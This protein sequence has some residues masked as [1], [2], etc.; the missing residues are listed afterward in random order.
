MSSKVYKD[1]PCAGM[2]ASHSKYGEVELIG[3]LSHDGEYSVWVVD[4][5]INGRYELKLVF[6]NDLH[7]YYYWGY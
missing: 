4:C 2:Y 6:E 3:K 5:C 7:K 1:E